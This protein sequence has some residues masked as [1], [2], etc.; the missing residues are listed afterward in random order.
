MKALHV[1][2][3]MSPEYGGPVAVVRA[4]TSALARQGIQCD[5]F[6]TVR[7]GADGGAKLSQASNVH[8]FETG[9]LARL[10]PAYSSDL[11]NAVRSA[12]QRGTFD[13]VHIHEPWHHAGFVVSRAA[14]EHGI[15]FVLTPHGSLQAWPLTHKSVRKRI[16]MRIVQDR[17]MKSA[18]ALHA[19]TEAEMTQMV[20]LGYETPAVV[21]P[22][23]VDADL[24]DTE[25][26]VSDFIVR[27]PQLA[28]KVVILF[29]GRLHSKKGLDLLARSYAKISR[30]NR[31]CTL[32]VAGPDEDDS[33]R[34][35][36]SILRTE[37]AL[38]RAVF[39]GMLTGRDK[40]AALSS[41]DVFVLPSYS[42]GFSVAVLEGLAA[43]LPAVISRQCNFPEVS[44]R[45][46][47]FVVEP[48]EQALTRA[49]STLVSDPDL[50]VAMGSNGRRLVREKYTWRAIAA[51]MAEL[52]RRL[53]VGPRSA[54]SASRAERRL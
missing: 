44:E 53:A 12:V 7:R 34:R 11:K 17:I 4:L 35:M 20:E 22:N 43:G 13:V 37:R 33:R 27:Y 2:A 18:E 31:D 47:G 3:S 28:G 46:A 15:P 42:E 52:Y 40:L 30:K 16:Y 9:P 1:I 5:I 50:R 54:W 8:L 32:L 41:A 51:S 26:D 38:D 25:I 10:W 6:S 24:F 21:V 19:L 23:G 45:A 14:I 39:T 36:E 48:D 49:I 29:L